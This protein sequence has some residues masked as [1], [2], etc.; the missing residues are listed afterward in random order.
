MSRRVCFKDGHSTS[1]LNVVFIDMSR[2][3]Y[4]DKLTH[5][6]NVPLSYQLAVRIP[7]CVLNFGVGSKD[8]LELFSGTQL[9]QYSFVKFKY[10]R[11]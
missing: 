9:S 8:I 1:Y 6:F 5:G 2:T 3:L 10:F 7:L 4:G 11:V